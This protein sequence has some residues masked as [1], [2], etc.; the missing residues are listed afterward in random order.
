MKYTIQT[1]DPQNGFLFFWGH[2][3]PNGY[4]S[5][6]YPCEFSYDNINFNC[7]E[8]WMMYYKAKSM[9]NE[10]YMKKILEAKAPNIQK[11]L[12]RKI[13]DFDIG[14]WEKI[15]FEV[16]VKGNLLK[17]SQNEDLKEKLLATKEVLVEASPFDKIWG[18]GLKKESV[19][20]NDPQ[21]WNGQNLLGFAIME[22]RD[23]LCSK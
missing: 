12:G 19:N 9:N 6:W 3:N 11:R 8:Q 14:Y 18:I 17:F 15:K 13:P 4:L 20:A 23:L 5:Q 2:T 16:V 1:I 21:K 10:E 7:S 22:V